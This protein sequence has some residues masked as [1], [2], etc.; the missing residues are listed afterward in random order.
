MSS[1]TH[2]DAV[3]VGARCAGAA[4]AMLMAR[5]GMKVLAIDRG[6][7]GSDALSTHAMMRGAAIQLARWGLLE[8]VADSGAPPV[9][10]TS[11]HYGDEI[12]EVAIK[13]AHGVD[14]L[15]A[16]RR[17]ILDALLV[18]AAREAGVEI[19][20]GH[21]LVDLVRRPDGRVEGVVAYDPAG[22]RVRV[23][24]DLVV[25]A[26]GLGS[27]VAR[28]VEAPILRQGRH[29]TSVAFGYWSGLRQDGYHWHSVPGA[30]A[31]LIPT[32]DGLTCVFL[33]VPPSVF[34]RALR[35]DP[36]GLFPTLLGRVA[37]SLRDQTGNA[38]QVGGLRLFAGHKGL[39]RQAH[40][41]GWALVGDAGYFKDPL[42]AHGITDAFR[43]AELLAEA[44]ADGSDAAF[45]AYARIRDELS[46]DL[47]EVTDEIAAFQWDLA[48]LKDL[49]QELNRHMK[50][51]AEHMAAFPATGRPD[52][53][54]LAGGPG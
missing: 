14:A 48:Q 52:R 5:R 21:A 10:V 12:V 37:P 40:G 24:A 35:P 25:G 11:F 22:H 18:D 6:G 2:Y 17:T 7:Y 23:S 45:A 43:D 1:R 44:A 4:T 27:T 53:Q 15:Y 34:A 39:F 3:I 33:A 29:A 13:P 36:A 19:R 38:R 47:F 16:P 51:E 28:L 54:L 32:N 41:P 20:H 30:S 50:R 31:G 8:R 42:T 9:P 49:H 46:L 26:D